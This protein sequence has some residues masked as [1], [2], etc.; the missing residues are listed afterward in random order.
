MATKEILF[1]SEFSYRKN[2]NGTYDS[3][4]LSCFQTVATAKSLEELAGREFLHSL[5][6][7]KRKRPVPDRMPR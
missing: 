6:C 2:T 3:I 1:F 7:Y 5:E 4:C